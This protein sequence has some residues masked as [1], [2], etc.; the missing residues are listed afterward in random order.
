MARRTAT[1]PGCTGGKVMPL[2]PVSFTIRRGAPASAGDGR[3]AARRRDEHQAVQHVLAHRALRRR[4]STA[5]ARPSQ[6]ATLTM[7]PRH[8]PSQDAAD[9]STASDGPGDVVQRCRT[10]QTSAVIADEAEH[11]CG[12]SSWADAR[13][14][15]RRTRPFVDVPLTTNTCS[16]IM[17]N[18]CSPAFFSSLSSR[19]PRGPCSPGTPV[20]VARPVP[21]ACRRATRSGRS[22]RRPT[23]AIPRR[24]LEAPRAQPSGGDDDRSRP[25][26]PPAVSR[27][28]RP[29]GT[30]SPA[31]RRL[32]PVIG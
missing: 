27:T 23:T 4:R 25:G 1:S 19:S 13:P 16:C 3:R 24:R 26:S 28:P 2:H 21:I 12:A 11:G 20:P 5:T 17:T 9:R 6:Q 18:R 8:G 29:S 32:L 15:S 10:R 30:A 22:Q 7:K 31:V 14:R